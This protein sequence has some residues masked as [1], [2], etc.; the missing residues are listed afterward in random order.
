MNG[1]PD[2]QEYNLVAEPGLDGSL[3]ADGEQGQEHCVL[4]T[5]SDASP[6][7]EVGEGAEPGSHGS[8]P[9]AADGE[10]PSLDQ[11]TQG[12]SVG[13]RVPDS[14][15]EVESPQEPVSGCTTEG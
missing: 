14:D 9:L 1:E 4:E 13:A 11:V 3:E 12:E 6:D 8:P 15:S 5:R 2:W 7:R 10:H